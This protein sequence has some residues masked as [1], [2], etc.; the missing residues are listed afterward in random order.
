MEAPILLTRATGVSG[1][2][3]WVIAS[4]GVFPGAGVLA[5]P[6]HDPALPGI[7]NSRLAKFYILSSARKKGMSGYLLQHLMRFPLPVPET[8]DG[9]DNK[10]LQEI[11][12][13]VVKR[14]DLVKFCMTHLHLTMSPLVN[15]RLEECDEEIDTLVYRAVWPDRWR[16]RVHREL[17][18]GVK[19]CPW[20]G[21][22][23]I[24]IPDIQNRVNIC[25]DFFRLQLHGHEGYQIVN[26][27]GF[28]AGNSS[29]YVRSV[30]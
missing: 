13:L 16:D 11:A 23:L 26:S 19:N 10:L 22:I 7:L 30:R 24:N 6:C 12:R 29:T 9:P 20:H 27:T 21:Q 14:R 4:R 3:E 15:K 1:G 28:F 18:V 5:I 25:P 8:E 17:V 2:P